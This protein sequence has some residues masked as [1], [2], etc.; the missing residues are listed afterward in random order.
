MNK[1]K[2]ELLL[3]IKIL[4]LEKEVLELKLAAK[5][6][7]PYIT[8]IPTAPYI[9]PVTYPHWDTATPPTIGPTIVTCATQ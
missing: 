1:T 7:E 3:E 2:K 4:K 5:I 8:F 9:P 6:P